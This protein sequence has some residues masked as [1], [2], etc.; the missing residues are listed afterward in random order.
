[1]LN[2]MKAKAST[3]CPIDKVSTLNKL[4][5]RKWMWI[6][7][8]DGK[9]DLSDALVQVETNSA[10]LYQASGDRPAANIL[11]IFKSIAESLIESYSADSEKSNSPTE[12]N[13]ANPAE[14]DIK[15]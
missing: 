9:A 1:M 13:N 10:Q 6:P 14:A 12:N 3:S 5:E 2:K 4:E 8:I 7:V 15:G 11:E